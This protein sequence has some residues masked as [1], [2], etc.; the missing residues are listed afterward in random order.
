MAT[1][2]SIRN[3]SYE[4]N[5]DNKVISAELGFAWALRADGTSYPAIVT[6]KTHY[7][8]AGRAVEQI[9]VAEN[10]LTFSPSTLRTRSTIYDGIGQV[11]EQKDAEQLVHGQH[12]LRYAYDA[13]GSK[14][15]T[16]N[17]VGNVFVDAFDANGNQLTHKVLRLSPGGENDTYVSGSGN[18]PVAVLLTSHGYDQANR[19]IET[20]DYVSS[21]AVQ[22]QLCSNTTSAASC[23]EPFS[24]RRRMGACL[25]ATTG[26]GRLPAFTTSWATKSGKLTIRAT[27][28]PQATTPPRTGRST[29]LHDQPPDQCDEYRTRAAV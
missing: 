16:V 29:E 26:A 21:L 3:L 11:I 22:C 20:R 27:A 13:G 6:H 18:V 4:Y 12:G 8:L 10:T 5:A 7:D 24:S 25:I 14:I 15:A 23:G 1:A 9:D 28:R 2:A 19:R 17:A